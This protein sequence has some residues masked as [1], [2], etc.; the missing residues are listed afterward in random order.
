MRATGIKGIIALPGVTI[1]GDRRSRLR[2]R[3]DPRRR[4]QGMLCSERELL[5]SDEHNGI[6][7]LSGDWPIGTPA[8]V[9]LGL[10]DPMI[11]VKVTPNRPDALG[12]YGIARD[13]AAKGLGKLK[14]LRCRRRSPAAFESPIKVSLD[15]PDG[16]TQ[17][18]P[19]LRRALYPRR[20]ERPVA[21]LAAAPAQGHRP[22]PDLGA[23]RHHQL[24]HLRLWPAPACLRRRQGEG[25][26]PCAAREGRRDHRGARRQDLHAHT[27][28]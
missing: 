5:I 8:A 11:Y 28:A 25:Q 7:E 16:D 14:P 20:E 1:P 13:L 19:A 27:P 22:A 17:A 23:G 24:H 12:V 4:I 9:A 26:H 18:L 21:R 6:I 3:R 15:F 10:D 2:D